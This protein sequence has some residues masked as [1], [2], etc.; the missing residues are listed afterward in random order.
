M[1]TAITLLFLGT[2]A[3][4]AFAGSLAPTRP[5]QVVTVQTGGTT[6][7]GSS[8]NKLDTIVNADGST[9]PFTIPA[10]QVF[11][12]TEAEARGDGGAPFGT[13]QHNGQ[14]LLY[15]NGPGPAA[16]IS[17]DIGT[18]GSAGTSRP[19]F[20][21]PP[22]SFPTG[23]VVKAGTEICVNAINLST[24]TLITGNAVV[25]GFFARDK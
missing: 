11:V 4:V 21:A 2:L 24:G 12:I 22:H 5:S 14:V 10:G 17:I 25:H 6:C 9:G 16:L 20:S 3:G 8:N 13:N 15:R 23:V 1:K 18:L 19:A 7:S